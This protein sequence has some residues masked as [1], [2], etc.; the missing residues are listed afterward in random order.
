MVEKYDSV[1]CSGQHR[2]RTVASHAGYSCP[3]HFR[4]LE[5]LHQPA[6][7]VGSG[8]SG[9]VP[10]AEAEGPLSVQLEDPRGDAGATGETRRFRPFA[11]KPQ[12]NLGLPNQN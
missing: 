1:A 6:V 5:R 3:G 8:A 7:K 4:Y 11:G 12:L 9:G 2:H 10:A